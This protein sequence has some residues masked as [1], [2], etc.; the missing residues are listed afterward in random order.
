LGSDLGGSG[1]TEVRV[2]WLGSGLPGLV[3]GGVDEEGGGEENLGDEDGDA[4]GATAGGG[5]WFGVQIICGLNAI[6]GL[7][8][9]RVGLG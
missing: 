2:R 6:G 1:R 4:P 5:N 7:R 3:G 9:N 8:E